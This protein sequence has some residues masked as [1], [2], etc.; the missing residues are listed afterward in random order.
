MELMMV[1]SIMGIILAVAA[2]SF[3]DFR[4][5]NRLSAAGND[6]LTALQLARTESIKRQISVSLCPST[7][8]TAAVASCSVG[9]YRGWIVFQDDNGDCARQPA[10]LLVRGE[11]PLDARLNVQSDGRCVSFAPT[12]FTRAA[13]APIASSHVVFCDER[14]IVLQQGTN[15]SAARGVELNQSGRAHVTRDQTELTAWALACP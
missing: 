15:G 3:E 12:G 10:E 8:P 7:N 14:G 1:L 2:P 11:G 13:V 9:P 4:R 5:N 6:F